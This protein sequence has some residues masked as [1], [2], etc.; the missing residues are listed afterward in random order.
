MSTT[1]HTLPTDDHFF[2]PTGS[3]LRATDHA[4][5]RCDGIRRSKCN[6]MVRTEHLLTSSQGALS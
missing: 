4:Q 2:V 5:R 6:G 1:E 3:R